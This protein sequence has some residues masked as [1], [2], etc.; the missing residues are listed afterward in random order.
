M[1][2]EVLAR[3]GEPFFSTKP[4]GQGMGLGLFIAR[5]LSE[6]MGG[7]SAWSRSPGRERPPRSRSAARRRR[8]EARMAAEAEVARSLLIVEDDEVLRARLARAFRERGFEVREAGDAESG[9]PLARRGP[10]GVRARRPAAARRLGPRA[11]C[12]SLASWTPRRRRRADRLRQHRHRARGHPP[13]RDATTSPSPPTSRRSWPP[14]PGRRRAA[15]AARPCAGRHA[16]P[17]PRRV[18]AHQPRARRLRRQRLAGGARARHPPPLAAAQA[19]E[20]SRRPLTLGIT[21]ADA[22]GEAGH[23]NAQTRSRTGRVRVM[24]LPGGPPMPPQAPLHGV[25]TGG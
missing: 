18:G 3:V 5:T 24:G 19:R 21:K 9:A 25:R 22:P 6:Q 2:P 11:S 1:P 7:G 8:A 10:A 20:V 13:R 12:G 23:A 17:G 15:K 14:S 4:P 16:D